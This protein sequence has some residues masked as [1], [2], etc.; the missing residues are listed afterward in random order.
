MIKNCVIKF[1]IIWVN[2]MSLKEINIKGSYT[3]KGE[4]IL[5]HFLLPALTE[6]IKYD[7]ITGKLTI[8]SLLS[9]GNGLESLRRKNG[10]MRLIVGIHSLPSNIFDAMIYIEKFNEEINRIKK[11]LKLGIQA[12]LNP[13]EKKKIAII[14]KMIEEDLLTVNAVTIKDESVFFSKTMIIEDQNQN[15]VVAVGNANE[16]RN[17][18]GG[19]FEQL[20]V[21]TSWKNEDAVENQ[22]EFFDSLWYNINNNAYVIDITEEIANLIKDSLG[23]DYMDF[24]D[25]NI[26]VKNVLDKIS[27]MPVNFFVSGMIPSLYM[28]Q[29]RAVID[30]LSRWPVRV[31]FAD[32]V[33]LGKTFEAA[34]TLKYLHKFCNVKRI[35]ILTPKSVLKQWQDELSN[36]FDLD[37]W[38]FDS[39]RREY[40]SSKGKIIKIGNENPLGK[41]SPNLI[42]MSSQYVRGTNKN[43][44]LL[45][46]ED[47]ILPEILVV[48]EA[49]LARQSRDLS[50]NL[51]KT[52]MYKMLE[53]VSDKIPHIILMTATPMQKNANEYHGMLK[54]LGLPEI[55]QKEENFL[56]SLD[57]I[58]KDAITDLTDANNIF[59]LLYYTIKIMKPDLSFLSREEKEI[60][61]TINENY[62]T[63]DRFNKA[64]YIIKEWDVVK[65]IF[66]KIHP[67]KLLTVRNTRQSLSEIGYKFPKRNLYE[68]TLYDSNKT[69][70]FYINVNRYL[71]EDCFSVEKEI[72]PDKKLNVSFIRISYQQR[73]ASSLYSCITSLE[74]RMKRIGEIQEELSINDKLK[75]IAKIEEDYDDFDDELLDLDE[76]EYVITKKSGINY[77]N[78]RRAVHKEYLTLQSLLEESKKILVEEGDKKIDVSLELALKSLENDD[79]VLLFS[80]YTDTVNALVNTFNKI[81]KNLNYK[82]AIYTGNKSVIINNGIEKEC[83]KDYIKKALFS[84]EIRIVF[85]SDAASEGLNLQAARVLINVDVPW[86]PARLEQRIGRIARLGQKAENV[87]IYNVWYPDSVEAKM[88]QRIQNRLSETNIAVGE[89][90]E[91]VAENI[92]N[93]ILYNQ[94]DKSFEILE[95]IR[96]NIQKVALDKLWSKD[97]QNIT[98]SDLIREKLID[99]CINHFELIY[100]NTKD[101]RYSF[102]LSE[103]EMLEVS[104]CSGLQESINLKTKLINL[105][106]KDLYGFKLIS[107]N[108]HIGLMDV[109]VNKMIKT[110][111]IID[112]L[113]GKELNGEV[114]YD[115]YPIMIPNP[116]KLDM[117]FVSSE[118]Y[119]EK[120]C[121]WIESDDE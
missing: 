118:E 114:Y 85:C 41:G 44:G 1:L 37:M 48:D 49:H 39:S 108:Y 26:I 95:S 21:A 23:V 57:Y 101:K 105:I 22:K 47:T 111:K 50:G 18:L 110:D 77:D 102:K 60:I 67:S 115:D 13:L 89:C 120:P 71:T 70:L 5:K 52:R 46:E 74:R 15:K 53:S 88:Y 61:N 59:S 91:V 16:T 81:N 93:S 84:H 45:S 79:S 75:D 76:Y 30:A 109:K 55:W 32:E 64:S 25:S 72:N 68:K 116:R 28:H 90:P 62:E 10:E 56:N 35:M 14:A 121:L 12:L 29:E 38:I 20:M 83:D 24:F 40:I 99:L 97:N 92:K 112:V 119:S 87:D 54:L 8:D 98:E 103:N 66:I 73:L 7:R 42:L 80:R 58:M 9:I 27:S 65:K 51:K 96:N 104:S 11:E 82:Y 100:K 17:G 69:R 63:L 33:G 36:H 107:K 19:C 43:N 31:L 86:T 117:S 113:L 106:E 2:D 4:K 78:L 3:G 94:D 6:A 34:T